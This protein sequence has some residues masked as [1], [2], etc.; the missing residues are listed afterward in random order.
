MEP[1]FVYADGEVY[2]CAVEWKSDDYVRVDES[3]TLECVMSLETQM[4]QAV[5]E[6]MMESCD[7]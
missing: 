6:H 2:D 3:T 1:L 4:R 7:E 5:L